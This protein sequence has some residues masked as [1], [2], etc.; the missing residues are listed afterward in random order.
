[1]VRLSTSSRSAHRRHAW[2][3]LRSHSDTCSA[4]EPLKLSSGILV[5]KGRGLATKV[6]RSLLSA[7]RVSS[8]AGERVLQKTLVAVRRRGA[9]SDVVNYT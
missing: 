8:S 2:P 7:I 5:L 3:C 6:P 4:G 9:M 1:M